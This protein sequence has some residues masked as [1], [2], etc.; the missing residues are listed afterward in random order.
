MYIPPTFAE[1]N[2]TELQAFME[3]NSFAT[4]V[5]HDGDQVVA[6]HLPLL[7]D[8]AAAPNGRLI[9]HLARAN[10]QWQHADGQRVLVIFQ[11]P[12]AYISPRWYE[13]TNVVPT[14]NYVSLHAYGMLTIIEGDA[15]TADVL[16][17][18]VD[19]Y[20]SSLPEPWSAAEADP[21]FIRSMAKQ[22]VCFHI[23]IDELEGKFKLGQNH[24]TDRIQRVVAALK[25]RSGENEQ[26]IAELMS[27]FT[28]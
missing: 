20:E 25:Q 24:S 28:P 4:L 23:D 7:L 13:E 6:N 8:H 15:Q 26:A 5:S 2:R 16:A 9:G 17:R 11:G 12:H 3:Q 14:W 21:E 18:F 1:T 10:D 19:R 27:K 22:V